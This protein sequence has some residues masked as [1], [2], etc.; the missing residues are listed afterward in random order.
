MKRKAPRKQETNGKRQRAE[1]EPLESGSTW[2]TRE[3]LVTERSQGGSSAFL[4]GHTSNAEFMTKYKPLYMLGKGGFA[5]VYAG[6]RRAD[7]LPV[8]IKRI[9]K[10]DVSMR[11]VTVNGTRHKIPLEVLLMQK[12][13]GEP[14]L[15]GRATAV[16]ILD[17]YDLEQHIVLVMERP[18][19]CTDLLEFIDVNGPLEEDEAKVIM[20]QLVDASI[21]MHS[22]G[23]FHRDIKSEN[24][25]I[26]KCSDAPR[27]RIIDFGCAC[28]LNKRNKCFR[29]FSGTSAYVPPEFY[30]RGTY[31]A[32]PTTVWQLAALLYEMLDGY[33]HFT[34]K[35]FLCNE[36]NISSDLS[37][38]CQDFLNM[39]LALK[40]KDRATLE[41]ICRFKIAG[42]QRTHLIVILR[43]APHTP[44]MPA[45]ALHQVQRSYQAMNIILR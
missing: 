44:G 34:T 37:Q 40:L 6:K 42:I 24:V 25:L 39:C 17:W 2:E 10:L 32:G 16:S 20:R 28:I 12:A 11:S 19:P 8:A 26:E 45:S 4:L 31:R 33:L 13:G 9:P 21:Q 36:F 29:S 7:N 1:G 43:E 22:A 30:V 15:V 14:E 41:Q 38:D 5:S 23:V 18:V 27:V 35:G 3:V